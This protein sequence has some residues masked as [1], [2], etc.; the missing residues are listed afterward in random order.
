[1]EKQKHM[2]IEKSSCWRGQGKGAV[3]CYHYVV[4]I[5]FVIPLLEGSLNL[6]LVNQR[7]NV[8]T[9]ISIKLL[10]TFILLGFS[11]WLSVMATGCPLYSDN[12]DTV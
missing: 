8:V 3:R 12:K 6:I 7:Q 11:I 2:I 5:L 10:L 9:D 4:L 1:M